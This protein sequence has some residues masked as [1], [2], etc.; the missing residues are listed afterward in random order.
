MTTE[1]VYETRQPSYPDL[2]EADARTLEILRRR[3]RAPARR[4]GRLVRRA[5]VASDAAGL[6]LAFLAALLV[7]QS[8]IGPTNPVSVEMEILLFLATIPGWV[9]LAQ[10]HGLYDRDEQRPSHSTLDDVAGVFQLVTM[11]AWL[12]F[13]A[14]WLIGV[15]EP[16]PPKLITFWGTA[17]LFIVLARAGARALC[18]RT[19][20]YVQ[21]TVIVGADPVGR[22]V[23]QKLTDHPEFGVNLIGFVDSSS[24]REAAIRSG[25]RVLG[26]PE[27]LPALVRLYD[28]ERVLVAS[29]DVPS[30]ELEKL[31][32]SVRDLDVQVDIVPRLYGAVNPNSEIYTVE[33]FPMLALPPP[34]PTSLALRLKR[35]IDLIIAG[36]ALVAVAPLMI[37]IAFRLKTDSPGPVFYHHNRIGLDGKPFRVFKFRTMFVDELGSGG[38][39]PPVQELLAD[40]AAQE[41]FARTFKLASD[42][43]VT[44]FGRVLRR[45]SLD[46]L[47]QLLN[48][49]LGTMSLVGPRPVT[50]AELERY[51]DGVAT[52]LSFRPGLTGYWQINGRSRT[53]YDERV[54]LDMAYIRG[55]S[56]KLDLTILG[57]TAQVLLKGHGAY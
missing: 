24:D 10:L 29:C 44:R 43:R 13:G 5:L 42:P 1:S 25:L 23:A 48:V 7:F 40:A 3:E 30:A 55:W 26:T 6:S 46:E 34:R 37:F 22:L 54:R 31:I 35:A 17:V 28:I 15:V 56:L 36:A 52:L 21:N 41:E 51:G 16:Y 49:L 50:Q 39:A 14:S 47:P 9:V 32:R 19:L 18:R 27:E 8:Q 38:T 11:G 4:R 20:T 12:F 45:Y 57:K 53:H 33:G 2:A